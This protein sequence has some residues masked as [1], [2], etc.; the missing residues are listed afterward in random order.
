MDKLI[1]RRLTCRRSA[2]KCSIDAGMIVR[3][4]PVSTS[5]S[6]AATEFETTRGFGALSLAM[7]KTS[8]TKLAATLSGSG[9]AHGS[10]S[11]SLKLRLRRVDHR[12]WTAS[13][14]DHRLF[15]QIFGREIILIDGVRRTADRKINSALTQQS[16]E[17]SSISFEH[18]ECDTWVALGNARHDGG[19]KPLDEGPG[20]PDVQ[21]PS[22]RIGEKFDLLNASSQIIKHSSATRQQRPSIRRWLDALRRPVEEA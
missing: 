10:P 1:G 5:L 15:K 9:R 17:R 12:L 20:A 7:R 2:P 8:A 16:A 6:R 21:F 14:N 13:D 22:G 11:S 18:T 3:N 4:F 19:D